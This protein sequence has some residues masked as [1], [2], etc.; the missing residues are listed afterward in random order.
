MQS[1]IVVKVNMNIL[2]VK[3]PVVLIWCFDCNIE[4]VGNGQCLLDA[5]PQDLITKE[6]ERGQ[7]QPGESFTEDRQC[8]LVF[9]ETSKI[10]SYMVSSVTVVCSYIS[11]S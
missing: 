9:G 2:G 7:N 3:I 8:Q 1:P 11:G 6:Q 4:S 10:C 5:P